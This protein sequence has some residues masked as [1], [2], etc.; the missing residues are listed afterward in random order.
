M[1]YVLP[2]ISSVAMAKARL[3]T[4]I[5][6]ETEWN[7]APRQRPKRV[8]TCRTTIVEIDDQGFS[9]EALTRSRYPQCRPQESSDTHMHR[10]RFRSQKH[11]PTPPSVYALFLSPTFKMRYGR[12]HGLCVAGPS[13]R[14]RPSSSPNRM[15]SQSGIASTRPS[16]V[17]RPGRNTACSSAALAAVGLHHHRR[18]LQFA[19]QHRLRRHYLMVF[20][21]MW[22]FR[23]TFKV[24]VYFASLVFLRV[25]FGCTVT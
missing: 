19:D 15:S 4:N 8:A 11:V 25:S 13:L 23:A 7:R 17:S 21:A 24:N 12:C 9:P 1:Y 18:G 20:N 22:T 5:E 14:R 16:N 10:C 6:K 3:A 2:H